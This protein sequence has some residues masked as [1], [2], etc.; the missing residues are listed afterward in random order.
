[1]FILQIAQVPPLSSCPANSRLRESPPTSCTYC[2][3]WINKPPEPQVGSS[4]SI[5]FLRCDQQSK[6]PGDLGGG[7]ELAALLPCGVGEVFD[8]VFIGSTQQVRKLE[9]VVAQWDVGEVLDELDECA[10][11]QGPLANPAVEIDSLEDILERVRVGVFDGSKGLVQP[12]TDRRF[13]VG[14]ALV[15]PLVVGVVPSSLIRYEEIVLVWVSQLLFDQ[16]S[17]QTPGF[18]FRACSVARSSWNWSLS[19]FRNN[20]PKMNSLY[21]EASMLPRRMSHASNSFRS[22]RVMLSEN[23][24]PVLSR[25][26]APRE[27]TGTDLPSSARTAALL[28]TPQKCAEIYRSRN[29]A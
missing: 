16:V 11:V 24:D 25:R 23:L 20:I 21:S 13:Q 12:G 19:R 29:V 7:V 22:R 4:I 5:A 9:I 6:Q 18:V 14:D 1:M 10:V 28:H 26:A 3:D 8:K 27:V 17:L 2:F 15:V